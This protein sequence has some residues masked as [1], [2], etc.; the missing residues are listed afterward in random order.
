MVGL[1]TI[2]DLLEEI[3]GDI[4]DESDHV[5]TLYHKVNDYEFVVSGKMT[6]TDFNDE[7]GLDLS[8]DDVDTIAGYVVTELGSIPTNG[9]PM[10]L[11]IGYGLQL[12]TGHMDGSRL[13]TVY[14]R[15]PQRSAAAVA[16][17]EEA[18]TNDPQHMSVNAG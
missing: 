8:A 18:K 11:D 5:T 7:F 10:T 15:L 2:E 17:Q 3:V 16:A 9:H 4:D 12:V 6:I 13:E 1:A 14:L